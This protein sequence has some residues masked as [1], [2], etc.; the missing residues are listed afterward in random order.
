ME[1]P[2][3]KIEG[4]RNQIYMDLIGPSLF[5]AQKNA[6]SGQEAA[7]TAPPRGQRVSDL[8][9]PLSPGSRWVTKP[10]RP[11]EQRRTHKAEEAAPAGPEV[12]S[13]PATVISERT[14]ALHKLAEMWAS[15]N[16]NDR[17]S[18]SDDMA[19]FLDAKAGEVGLQL[20]TES[21]FKKH[22]PKAREAG[23][24]SWDE[25]SRRYIPKIGNSKRTAGNS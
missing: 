8:Y 4:L 1:N 20:V 5:D 6:T 11:Q 15:Y 21:E 24:I 16:Q 23:I 12:Q 17:I 7:S 9:R 14:A 3:P 10:A 19:W 13:Q 25:K 22:L 18:K 2:D